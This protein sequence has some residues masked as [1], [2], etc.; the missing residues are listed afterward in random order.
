MKDHRIRLFAIGAVALASCSFVY[1][2]SEDIA[3]VSA[4]NYRAIVAP[5]S[6]VA[7]WGSNLAAMTT[8]A[9]VTTGPEVTLPTF[10]GGI[11][12][13]LT[14]S[15]DTELTPP[16]YLV[17]PG[18]INYVVPDAAALG[19][20]KL[21]VQSGPSSPMGTV[22]V[23]NVAPGLFTFDASGEG[24]PAAQVLRITSG[25]EASYES[26]AAQGTSTYV[27]R[28][29]SLDGSSQVYLVLYGTGFR[30]HSLNPVIAEIDGVKVP[31]LYAAGQSQYPGLDQI[32]VG[33]LPM[34]LTG[35]GTVDL[36]VT[37]DGVPANTVQ[38]AI[39]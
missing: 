8:A 37:T 12:L 19:A 39:Q 32:N 9:N 14:D 10:L 34:E 17:S 36:V 29:I 16:L 18:Q 30:Q 26:P 25:G 3:S 35:R 6:I 13:S 38:I 23:S 11:Q 7:G 27:P 5:S 1:G 20:A 31:V 21:T 15:A 28:P 22:L 2:Q 4:A 33:P 24:V